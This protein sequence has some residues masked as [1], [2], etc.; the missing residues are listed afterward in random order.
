MVLVPADFN[1]S[2][3]SGGAEQ[4]VAA[5][6]RLCGSLADRKAVGGG[7]TPS[8][9]SSS[10]LT[11]IEHGGFGLRLPPLGRCGST[12]LAVPLDAISLP[13]GCV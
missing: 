7:R 9:G 2:L 12:M 4:L 10:L 8:G 11:A 5:G 6:T 3:C 13:R 1:V